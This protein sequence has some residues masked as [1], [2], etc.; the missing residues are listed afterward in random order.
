M[1]RRKQRDRHRRRGRGRFGGL[2]KLL[3]VLIIL[4]ALGIGCVAFFRVNE[5]TVSGNSRYTAQEIAE[6]SG[7]EK[8]D[9]LFLV[10][11]SQTV[12]NILKKLPYIERG[13]VVVHPPDRLEL[14]VV[15][16]AP[17]CAVE[18]EGS[19]WTLSARCKLLE[20]GGNEDLAL[21]LGLT[22][23][24]PNLGSPLAVSAEEE[25][26]LKCLKSLLTALEEQGLGNEL[27]GFVDMSGISAIYFGCGEDLTVKVPMNGDFD[28]LAYSLKQVL[29]TFEEQGQAVSGTLDLTYGD[30]QARL[31]PTRW[32]PEGWVGKMHPGKNFPKL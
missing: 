22:P 17:V 23:Q 14:K 30:E 15:E 10:N 16:A 31:L 26:K 11:R 3:S 9:N 6:A 24:T 28:R 21:V 5:V 20:L 1:A 7:V 27:S 12:A 25:E 32:L 4:L 19:R 2:Y 8:G 29:K 18:A 13:A